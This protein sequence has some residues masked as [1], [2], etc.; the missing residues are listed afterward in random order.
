MPTKTIYVAESD[1]PIFEKAQELAGSS[2][3][4]VIVEALREY[5]NRK[6]NEARGFQQITLR[7][8]PAGAWREVRFTGRLLARWRQRNPQDLRIRTYKV[9]QTARGKFA[10]FV[11]DMPD[12]GRWSQA[13]WENYP[14]PDEGMDR[15]LEVYDSLEALKERVP[16]EVGIAAERALQGT[17]VE[18]LDI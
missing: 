17:R 3:S 9:F 4:A 10:V 5:I 8:G 18:E 15:H 2:L 1:L 14:W 6:E 11:R 13:G 16:R 12:W 7:L